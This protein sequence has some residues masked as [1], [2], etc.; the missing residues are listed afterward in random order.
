M[1]LS[2]LSSCGVLGLLLL[3]TNVRAMHYFVPPPPTEVATPFTLWYA[4]E[5][6]PFYAFAFSPFVVIPLRPPE[7]IG[8]PAGSIILDPGDGDGVEIILSEEVMR[9]STFLV[10]RAIGQPTPLDPRDVEWFKGYQEGREEK[11]EWRE[12]GKIPEEAIRHGT[13]LINRAIGHPTPLDP[14]DVEW[15]KGVQERQA[16]QLEEKR[17]KEKSQNHGTING[18]T[19]PLPEV[20]MKVKME[21]QIN[22][23]INVEPDTD[24]ITIA[25]PPEDGGKIWNKNIP[26]ERAKIKNELLH[27][28]KALG[29]PV[30]DASLEEA[31]NH[32]KMEM[33]PVDREGNPIS[34]SSSPSS[35]SQ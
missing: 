22:V 24:P 30:D 8:P 16:K 4:R 14:R 21:S 18:A 10:N 2:S 1:K 11:L 17:E 7:R 26:A 12:G 35:S 31:V 13:F 19:L 20:H 34:P 33:T 23:K 32:T 27:Y 3:G 9:R 28:R 5:L 29:L 25:P 15:W 6:A